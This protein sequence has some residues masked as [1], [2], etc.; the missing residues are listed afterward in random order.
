MLKLFLLLIYILVS[1]LK[2]VKA[3]TYGSFCVFDSLYGI[4]GLF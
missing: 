1:T 4:I 2:K 3:L